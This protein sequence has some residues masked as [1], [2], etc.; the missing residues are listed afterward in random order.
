VEDW[1]SVHN[2]IPRRCSGQS[3]I[4]LTSQLTALA[5]EA[6]HVFP[7][8]SLSIPEGARLLGR[9][10]YGVSTPNPEEYEAA[11]QISR[12]FAAFPLSLAHIGGFINE[13]SSSIE[14]YEKTF[15]A[16]HEVSWKGM[17]HATTTQYGKPM[18]SVWAFALSDGQLSANSRQL[19]KVLSFLD[20]DCIPEG[21]ILESFIADPASWGLK[22]GS[23]RA[24]YV[25]F[26]LF[27]YHIP[28]SRLRCRVS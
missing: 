1:P 20:P 5:S 28:L 11:L 18:E 17:T 21:M 4:L 14:R 22:A 3:G 26:P 19:L 25:P 6:D 23:E 15:D 2:Y 13:S 24:E 27:C 16:R 12:R 10:V 8:K 9:H 7:L